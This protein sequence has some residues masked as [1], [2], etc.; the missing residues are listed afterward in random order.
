MKRIVMVS[1]AAVLVA[2]QLVAASGLRQLQDEVTRHAPLAFAD[3]T[4]SFITSQGLR[5]V[6]DQL[7]ITFPAG[8]DLTALTASDVSLTY[9]VTG[10]ET[11]ATIAAAPS[12]TAWGVGVSG[13]DLIFEHPTDGAVGDIAPN[14]TVVIRIGAQVGVNQ[15]QNPPDNGSAIIRLTTS[16]GESG[17]LAVPIAPDQIG[18]EATREGA[19]TVTI[20]WAVPQFRIGTPGTNDDLTFFI[21]VMTADDSDDVVLFE[22]STLVTTAVDGT[23]STPIP[24]TGLLPGVYDVGIKGA[25]HITKK[26]DNVTLYDGNN[27]L[28]FTQPD[29]SVTKGSEVLIA[30]DINGD[31]TSSSTL[32]DDQINA[33]DISVLIGFVD[34]FDLT[35]NT[36]RANVNQ[37]TVVNAIDASILIRNLNLVG[38]Q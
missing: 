21:R 5:D 19:V 17:A 3:H 2:W 38:D 26:L 11:A 13:Q 4:I 10:T 37:D 27:V 28:N 33:T 22:Q 32:G 7:T 18:V 20:Q 14:D 12:L 16:E 36:L 1:F 23:Y 35:G 29:N 6:G 31:G 24:L 8:F 34:E 9:G 15:I 25:A 30:G